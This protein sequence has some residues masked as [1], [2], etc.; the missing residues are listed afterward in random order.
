MSIRVLVAEDSPTARALLVAMLEADPE[1]EVVAE[2]S[3][4][5]QAVEMAERLEPDL[6]T[7]DVQMPELDG[8]QATEQIMRRSPRPIII[9][10][11]QARDADVRLSLD[12]TRAGALLV[13]PKPEGPGSGH[14]A[15]DQR[16]LVA[17]VKALSGVKVVRRWRGSAASE[18]LDGQSSTG[19]LDQAAEARPSLGRGARAAAT[20]VAIAASTGGPAALRDLLA[21]LPADFRAPILIVQ[22]IAKG[23]VEGLATWLGTDSRLRVKV[24]VDGEQAA[25]GSVYIAPDGRHLELRRDGPD[26]F[27]IALTSTSPVGT[28]RPSA[29]R[30]FASVASAAGAR[31]LSVILTGMGDDGVAGLRDVRRA[32]GVIIAQ[33]EKSSVIF[34]MPREAMR[35]GVVD[36]VVSLH[37]LA[38]RLVELT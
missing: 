32:N 4:G 24:A 1:I 21:A 29:T 20:I 18:A 12:A 19:V 37:N 16:Q 36:E 13:L 11:S 22:H 30:L 25:P 31:A 33:D 8:L 26:R 3:T 9:V 27:R 38:S 17:M 28:F 34:G 14:F 35:A 10:S 2:A 5:V 23:F 15:S 6:I 7:M